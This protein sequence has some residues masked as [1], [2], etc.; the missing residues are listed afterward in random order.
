MELQQKPKE[1]PKGPTCPRCNGPLDERTGSY[2]S[3][4]LICEECTD[5]VAI[6]AADGIE[7]GGYEVEGTLIG[8]LAAGF[9]GGCIGLIL[10][11][12]IAKGKET[13]KGAKIGFGAA[14]AFNIIVRLLVEL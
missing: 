10:V 14:I 6:D 1:T 12:M 4:G 5:K 13:K 3:D 7:E 2:S 9:F 11:M 8:G